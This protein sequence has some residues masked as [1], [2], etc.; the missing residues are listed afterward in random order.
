MKFKKIRFSTELVKL[1]GGNNYQSH[2]ELGREYWY[3]FLENSD[4]FKKTKR[5]WNKIRI[6]Y[7][8]SG[9]AFFICVNEPGIAEDFFSI[10]SFMASRLVFAEIDP[11]K[12]LDNFGS[13][14]DKKLYCFDDDHTIVKNWPKEI[15]VEV[16]ENDFSIEGKIVQIMLEKI[17]NLS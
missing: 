10:N 8:R 6:T 14:M 11:L 13:D 9:C 16:D 5:H 12:D 15:E 7:L 1:Y 17:D 4:V 2:I 3:F